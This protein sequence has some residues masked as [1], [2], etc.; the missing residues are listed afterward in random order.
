MTD[1]RYQ[2]GY[3]GPRILR[4][5]GATLLGTAAFFAL[6]LWDAPFDPG[7][8]LI[9]V[10]V[11]AVLG[12]AAFAGGILLPRP[13]WVVTRDGL[14]IEPSGD[15]VSWGEI[16]SGRLGP[17]YT[18][19]D[20]LAS[21]GRRVA[22]MPMHHAG[23]LQFLLHLVDRRPVGAPTAGPE[24]VGRPSSWGSLLLYGAPIVAALSSWKGGPGP[25]TP[26][27]WIGFGIL[28]AMV[29]WIAYEGWKG[30]GEVRLTIDQGSIRSV[31]RRGEYV[32]R[33]GEVVELTLLMSAFDERAG[34]V[35]EVHLEAGVPYRIPLAGMDILGVLA[36]LR[37]AAPV[38]WSRLVG[39]TSTA[40]GTEAPLEPYQL[41]ADTSRYE[42]VPGDQFMRELLAKKDPPPAGEG[43]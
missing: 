43:P 32:T 4:F 7:T 25:S 2:L 39:T 8:E 27:A 11:A 22:S 29:A 18:S 35:L 26:T 3:G 20:L 36:A 30:A 23:F 37:R 15:L 34:A 12:L 41:A 40:T 16:D 1:Y 31:G 10:G 13:A 33:W 38:H 19:F 28:T 42:E 21:D 24:F 5:V 6:M 14:R 17:R 9:A